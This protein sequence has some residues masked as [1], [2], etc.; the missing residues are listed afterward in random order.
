VA[1]TLLAQAGFADDAARTLRV[2]DDA[3]A[4]P[5][6]Q[7]ARSRALG[8][9]AM[10]R[11]Q[12]AAGIG[13]LETAARLTPRSRHTDYLAEAYAR[14][15]AVRKAADLY[16]SWLQSPA[17]MWRA[18]DSELPGFLSAMIQRSAALGGARI[19]SLAQAL[20]SIPFLAQTGTAGPR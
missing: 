1:A 4:L 17:W 20:R 10:A 16:E 6:Y 7:I 14:T 2:L 5:V 9:I 15:G 3:P 13:H 11:G 19:P 8:E 12:T 18:P